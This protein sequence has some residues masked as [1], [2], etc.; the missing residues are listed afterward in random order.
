MLERSEFETDKT[1]GTFG[2]KNTYKIMCKND[3]FSKSTSL[4]FYLGTTLLTH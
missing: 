3:L 1:F 2:Y 4:K